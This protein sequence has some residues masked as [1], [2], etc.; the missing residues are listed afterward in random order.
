MRQYGYRDAREGRALKAVTVV[1]TFAWM[2]I[3][4]FLAVEFYTHANSDVCMLCAL[5]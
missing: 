3:C 1:Y 4:S 2:A 5:W